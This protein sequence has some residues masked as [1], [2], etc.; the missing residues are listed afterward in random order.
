[1]PTHA[2]GT[3]PATSYTPPPLV[4]EEGQMY[5]ALSAP[6]SIYFKGIRALPSNVQ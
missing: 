4:L 1:M 3:L 2:N 6:H 5:M